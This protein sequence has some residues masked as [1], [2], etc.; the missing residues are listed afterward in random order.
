MLLIQHLVSWLTNLPLDKFL[1]FELLTISVVLLVVLAASFDLVSAMSIRARIIIL[2]AAHI[3]LGV[4]H[5]FGSATISVAAL[6][7]LRGHSGPF[8]DLLGLRNAIHARLL[9]LWELLRASSVR[10]RDEGLSVEGGVLRDVATS[11]GHVLLFLIQTCICHSR[12]CIS[13]LL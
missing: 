3:F 5:N 1:R 6:H 10:A 12:C 4:I 13:S 8:L 11:A 2:R 7:L 9:L